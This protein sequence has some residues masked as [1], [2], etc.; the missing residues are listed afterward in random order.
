VRVPDFIEQRTRH[1]DPP[2]GSLRGSGS[3]DPPR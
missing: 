2:A 3:S 1:A